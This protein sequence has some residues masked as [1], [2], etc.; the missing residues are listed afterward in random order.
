MKIEDFKEEEH[1]F[2]PSKEELLEAFS[3]LD[4]R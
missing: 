4:E 1:S 3:V 2:L